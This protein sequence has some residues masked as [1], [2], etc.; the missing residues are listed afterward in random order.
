MRNISEEEY[1]HLKFFK[2]LYATSFYPQTYNLEKNCVDY[3]DFPGSHDL[4]RNVN[5]KL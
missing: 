5:K 1:Q 2:K 4:M 3:P